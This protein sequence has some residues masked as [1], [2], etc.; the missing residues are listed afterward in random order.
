MATP[1][2]L[3]PR[4]RTMLAGA[5]AG[6]ALCFIAAAILWLSGLLPGLLFWLLLIGTIELIGAAALAYAGRRSLPR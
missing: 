4:T 2:P 6:A 1:D 3:P 5:L